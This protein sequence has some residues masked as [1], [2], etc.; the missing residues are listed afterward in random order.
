MQIT[1]VKIKITAKNILFFQVRKLA[2]FTSK[3]KNT[4]ITCNLVQDA[5]EDLGVFNPLRNVQGIK[6][7][8][9]TCAKFLAVKLENLNVN[10]MHENVNFAS[11]DVNA[12]INCRVLKIISMQN[13]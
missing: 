13:K 3:A 7:N 9:S 12:M 6:L 5:P 8:I 10:E 1:A 2:F 11:S 4:I